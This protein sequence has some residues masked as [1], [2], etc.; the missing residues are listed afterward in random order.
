MC[1]DLLLHILSTTD[2]PEQHGSSVATDMPE[3]HGSSVAMEMAEQHGSSVAAM[4]SV[5]AEEFKMN[6]V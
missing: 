3:Q 4:L 1:K 6:Q 5:L 2:M